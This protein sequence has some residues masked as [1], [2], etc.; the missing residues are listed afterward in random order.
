ME[1]KSSR[2]FNY[3]FIGSLIFPG[4][5][6]TKDLSE[7]KSSFKG[8]AGELAQAVKARPDNIKPEGALC[9]P[10]HRYEKEIHR[11]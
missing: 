10:I 7:T 2:V 3:A 4:R 5:N 9:S 1:T 6:F 8:A 11:S